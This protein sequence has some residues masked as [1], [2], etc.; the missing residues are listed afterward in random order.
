VLED[1]EAARTARS[2]S[3]SWAWGV[4]NAAM[5]A[6]PANF[7]TVPP[8]VSMQY[9]TPSKNLVTWRRVISGS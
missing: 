3:S 2:A 4:P 1:P 8:C 6:S 7:Y 5:T 9:E